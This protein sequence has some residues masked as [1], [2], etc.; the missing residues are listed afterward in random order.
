MDAA[1]FKDHAFF[2]AIDT[3]LALLNE[4]EKNTPSDQKEYSNRIRAVGSYLKSYRSMPGSLF[5]PQML[6]QIYSQWMQVNGVVTNHQVS[7][8]AGHLAQSSA[9]VDGCLGTVASWPLLRGSVGQ[10]AAEFIESIEQT[11]SQTVEA[12]KAEIVRA[13]E[14]AEE[15][16]SQRVALAQKLAALDAKITQDET[17][18]DNAVTTQVDGFTNAQTKRE[19]TFVEW[20]ATRRQDYDSQVLEFLTALQGEN[21]RASEILHGLQELRDKTEHVA[22]EATSAKLARD[23]GEYS[24]REYD[25]AKWAY[26][27]GIL[28]LVG[29]A[30]FLFF[31]I[32][33]VGP[34]DDVSWE[35]VSLKLGIAV[36]ALG[37]STIAIR[38]GGRFINNSAINKRVELE[39]RAIGPFLADVGDGKSAVGQAKLLFVQ[40]AFGRTWEGDQKH[41]EDE[42]S[43][44]AATKIIEAAGNLMGRGG[45]Q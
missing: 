39:L 28:L 5:S 43:A 27:I 10:K 20:L 24:Q 33:G 41:T 32:L 16:E 31:T 35:W 44:T 17:R 13:R 2:N 6:D 23:Y 1:S 3:T 8:A 25:S 4:A 7:P 29:A 42:V 18:L 19:E 22:G 45:P 9:M 12:L 40:R 14:A 26:G 37:A 15:A 30:A 38:L 21:D 34:T 36:T 11:S